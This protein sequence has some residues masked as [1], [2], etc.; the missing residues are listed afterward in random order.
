MDPFIRIHL[1]AAQLLRQ[2]LFDDYF[3]WECRLFGS[4]I[5]TTGQIHRVRPQR[6]RWKR[7]W[8]LDRP[9]RI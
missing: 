6:K 4:A 2:K 7:D 1:A 3:W 5:G 8:L 9:E